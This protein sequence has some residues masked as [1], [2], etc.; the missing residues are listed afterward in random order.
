MVKINEI[1]NTS[2]KKL[3]L[4]L[5][6]VL[7]TAAFTTIFLKHISENNIQSDRILSLP[8]IYECSPIQITTTDGYPIKF[9]VFIEPHNQSLLY[10]IQNKEY[11]IRKEL[12]EKI[13]SYTLA[14]L[15]SLQNQKQISQICQQEIE[16]I[17]NSS[18]IKNVRFNMVRL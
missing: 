17:L 5:I 3:L 12:K 4:K 16:K 7:I 13:S 2:D 14:Y 8:V 6:I 18:T 11:L 1:K 10:E 9:E 15:I